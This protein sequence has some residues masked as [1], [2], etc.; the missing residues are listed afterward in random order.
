MAIAPGAWPIELASPET[1]S[2]SAGCGLLAAVVI[3]RHRQAGRDHACAQIAAASAAGGQDATEAVV[4]IG[5]A[6]KRFSSHQSGEKVAR[7]STTWPGSPLGIAAGLVQ[8]WSIDPQQANALGAEVETVP[9]TD[10][11]PAGNHRIGGVQGR[12]QY[13]AGQQHGDGQHGAKPA[14]KRSPLI[15]V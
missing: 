6:I 15:E 2:G 10:P 3:G 1:T 7:H 4:A 8:L 14:A 13:G 12:S 9:V 5:L 11:R